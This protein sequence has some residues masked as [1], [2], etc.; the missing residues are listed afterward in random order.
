MTTRAATAIVYPETDGMPLPDGEYQ[1]PLYRRIVL[2]LED[3]FRQ[4]SGAHV[5]GD[6]F[7]YYVE[8]NPRRLVS[9][10]CYV[11]FGLSESALAIA[12][13]GWE[14]HLPAAGSGQS[15]GLRAGDRLSKYRGC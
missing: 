7:L 14:Q 10:N 6:T 4:V 9:P 13:S 8:D 15:T 11:V 5:N 3:H 12:V 1:A 2:G